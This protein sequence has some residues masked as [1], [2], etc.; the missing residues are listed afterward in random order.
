M[1][2][3]GDQ[4]KQNL[5]EESNQTWI[6]DIFSE[7]DET[8]IEKATDFVYE[9][10]PLFLTEKDYQHF[11][12]LLTQEGIEAMMRKNYTN[13]LSPAGIALR[14]YI[15]RDP[16]GLGNNVLKHLQDFQLETNYEIND[17]HIFSKDGNTLLMFMTPVFGTGSTGENENL[18]RI[19]ENELQ[20]VQKE[21]PSIRASYFGGPSVSVYNARQIKKDTI[22]TSSIALLIII[23]FISLV[24]KHKKSIP[25][26]VT[27]VLFGGLFALC[28]IY[29]IQGYISAIAVG[30]GSAILGIALSY[31]IH[32]LAHQNHVSTVQQLIKEITYPLTVGSF[33]TIGFRLAYLFHEPERGDIVIFKYP[34][35]ESQNFVK[36]VIGIPGDV[37]QISNG[38]VYVNGEQLE[39][40][41]LR[42]PMNNDGEELTY[43]VP[44][45]SYFML[46]DNR[47]NSKDSRYWTNTF[48]S[49]DKIIAKVSFR[50]F[51]VRTKR[52]TFSFI[53]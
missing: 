37:I 1:I 52:F 20:Q 33:T 47:N 17:G 53:K 30:A 27:P 31:S 28:L 36:R 18:I 9:N 51:N 12:S 25:L 15:Q 46:G 2:E 8:T 49:K 42:E 32:M 40:N 24:F 13:L 5:L 35:D 45:D 34:D 39:E 19:L 29:F 14:G 11:D 21:Y 23:V 7:V 10:L 6:K 16:L 44:A 3:V 41:Y 48:V 38:H 22:I 50:Y 26:I 4:L 43:V